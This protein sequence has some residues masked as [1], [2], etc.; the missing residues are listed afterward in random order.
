MKSWTKIWLYFSLT[1]YI[2]VSSIASAHAFPALASGSTTP[3]NITSSV[4]AKRLGM[5]S[6]CHQQSSGTAE[7]KS[8]ACEIFCACMAS[9]ISNQFLLELPSIM[10]NTEITFVEKN[11]LILESNLEPH[12]PK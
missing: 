8:N 1:C 12:P 2:A 6:N 4:S 5:P 3:Q 11:T 10:V 9:A 7:N